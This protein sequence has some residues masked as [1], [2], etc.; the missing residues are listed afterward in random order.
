MILFNFLM[1][2]KKC[3]HLIYFIIGYSCLFGQL[4]INEFMSSNSNTIY[5][6]FGDSPDWIEIYNSGDAIFLEG[7]GLS[8][9]I[10]DPYKWIFPQVTISE[11]DF[12]L[13]FA[14]GNDL[15]LYINHWETIIN[16]G[17]NWSYFIG[18]TN[19]PSNW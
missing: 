4:F 14:S 11:N 7:Y 9:E 5:D 8:D 15:E 1:L 16:W 19:P 6:E 3:R 18:N 2:I 10:N 17:D 13:L 12:I